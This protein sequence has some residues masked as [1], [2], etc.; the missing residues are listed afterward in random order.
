M[1]LV[2]AAA[3]HVIDDWGICSDRRERVGRVRTRFGDAHLMY[4]YC[5]YTYTYDNI[6]GVCIRAQANGVLF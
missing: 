3:A 4:L 5:I 2:V 6:L 1:L